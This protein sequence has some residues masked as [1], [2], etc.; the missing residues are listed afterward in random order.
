MT[1]LTETLR[2]ELNSKGSRTKVTVSTCGFQYPLLMDELFK[3][4]SPGYVRTG[5]IGAAGLD[6]EKFESQLGNIQPMLPEDIADAA[7]YVLSTP[8]HVQV[9][10]LTLRPVGQIY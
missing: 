4:I 10:E 7:L 2:Q 9:H 8:P 5:I 6:M 3:S 1:A